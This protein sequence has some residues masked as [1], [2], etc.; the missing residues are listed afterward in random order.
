MRQWQFVQHLQATPTA[1]NH[2]TSVSFTNIRPNIR[3]VLPY[4]Q[5]D[6][7][8]FILKH[9]FSYLAIVVEC[10]DGYPN[11]ADLKEFC[12]DTV[13][14]PHIKENCPRTCGETC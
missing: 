10:T 13:H 1:V 2:R 12:S 4:R 5:N 9:L 3:I 6:G 11:C 8:H 7:K 14:N